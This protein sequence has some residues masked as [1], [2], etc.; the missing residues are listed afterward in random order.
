[1]ALSVGCH[2]KS[3][4]KSDSK[5]WLLVISKM[6]IELKPTIF[7]ITCKNKQSNIFKKGMDASHCHTSIDTKISITS[8]MKKKEW[9]NAM[10]GI[11][12][13]IFFSIKT[14]FSHQTPKYQQASQVPD[15]WI[16]SI[17][18]DA[19][20]SST[21]LP[22]FSFNLCDSVLLL[23]VRYW[24]FLRS[25][26]WFFCLVS[27]NIEEVLVFF[28]KKRNLEAL[29]FIVFFLVFGSSESLQVNVVKLA[30]EPK[31]GKMWAL[32]SFFS[33]FLLLEFH[34]REAQL[35]A[36]IGNWFLK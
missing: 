22:P 19:S 7:Q 25:T 20:A 9:P 23:E 27:E 2:F 12:S 26:Q 17:V 21:V 35:K 34:D 3:L 36:S 11:K 15:N 8:V 4:S 16:S 18:C 6:W 13:Y 10:H 30:F 31:Q 5:G 29:H 28:F 14:L 1:M 24:I 33:S 32:N